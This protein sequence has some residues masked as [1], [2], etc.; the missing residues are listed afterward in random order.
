VIEAQESIEIAKPAAAVFAYATA[1]SNAPSWLEAC[2]ELT[3]TSP[4]PLAAGTRLHYVH[5]QGGHRGEMDGAVTNF[6]RDR[7]FAMKFEDRHFTVEIE[8]QLASA[9]NST[10]VTH[11]IVI[12]PRALLGKLMAPMIRAGNRKQVTANL[13]RLKRQLERA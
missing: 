1:T 9:A 3:P 4:G 2:V 10:K 6:E 12:T 5:R 11:R 13:A 7:S 8:L